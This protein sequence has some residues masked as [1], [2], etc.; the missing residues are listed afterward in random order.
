MRF[1]AI[2][3][4]CKWALPALAACLLSTAPAA[5]NAQDRERAILVLDGSGSMWG[6]IDGVSKIEIARGEIAQML[7]GWDRDIDLGLMSYGHRTK[8]D[9]NDIELVVP[10]RP[11]D[12]ASFR[13]A[14][15]AVSPKGKTPLSTAVRMA[16]EEMRFTEERATVILLSD[17]LETC[18]ADPCALASALEA[19]GVDFTTHVI[20]FDLTDTDARQLSCL[21]EN[22]GGRFFLAGNSGELT[23]ALAET[24]QTIAVAEPDPAPEP[25]VVAE[26]Q[27]EPEP[28]PAGPQGIRALAKLCESCDILDKDVFWYVKEPEADLN[29]N[30]KEVTR[31][32][33]P[34]PLF[35]LGQ[36]DFIVGVAYGAAYAEASFS[37]APGQLTEAVINLNAGNLRIGAQATE[38]GTSLDDNM[39]YYVYE[40]KK[41][42]EGNRREISRSGSA[43]HIFRLPAGDYH[44]VAFHGK[45]RATADLSV[46]AGELT[47]HVFDMDAGY[48]RITPIP[49]A[50]AE[51]LTDNQFYYVYDA[52][53]DLEGN[54]REVTRSGN[55]KPLFRLN[56]GD[57][58]VVALHGKA[59][60]SFDVT[61]A[62]DGLADETVDMN[63][64][65]LRVANVLADGQPALEKD[66]FYYVYGARKDL[67][68][69]RK[70]VTRSGNAN[71]LFRLNAGDYHIVA[72]HGSSRA[73]ADVTVEAGALNEQTMVQ[74]AAVLSAETVLEEGGTALDGGVFW[75][76]MTGEQDLEGKR[77]EVTRSGNAKPIFRLKEGSYVLNVR[78][79]NET[80]SFP[81]DLTAGETRKTSFLLKK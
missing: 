30:R 72:V 77:A 24:V 7:T 64:G 11:L 69:N 53:K 3:R 54:R 1:T 48:L 45:A 55:A 65:Y 70:E 51:P 32:G 62:A 19:Q 9:C 38:G 13:Q 41:D 39:F 67:E 29:G 14:V 10:P 79:G 20:G 37:V 21:A 49:T 80:Y 73:T 76:V 68:G 17:G 35:E 63:V 36:G 15:N 2:N 42:L 43:K 81:V 12:G 47:D 8:G 46:K 33:N 50:G 56:A 74:N 40:A 44:V 22:T 31:S 57:Y 34:K 75:Y 78:Y 58:H 61:V 18:E 28:E 5:V 52:R 27:P 59:R 71:P 4:M 23:E 60:A 26:A 6:R 16:A 25:V 66:L